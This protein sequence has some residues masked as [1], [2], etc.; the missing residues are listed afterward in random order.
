MGNL[1]YPITFPKQVALYLKQ[2]KYAYKITN[3]DKNNNFFDS[4]YKNK[5]NIKNNSADNNINIIEDG[6]TSC[7]KIINCKKKEEVDIN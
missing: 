1:L 2:Q 4:K 5:E 3:L 7:G 6:T